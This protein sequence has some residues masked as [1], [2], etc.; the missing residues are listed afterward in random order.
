MKPEFIVL[1]HEECKVIKLVTHL[2]TFLLMLGTSVLSFPL[3]D[4]VPSLSM[5]HMSIYSTKERPG[6]SSALWK[7]GC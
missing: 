4:G 6:N 3:K 5:A 1:I 7:Q 2:S